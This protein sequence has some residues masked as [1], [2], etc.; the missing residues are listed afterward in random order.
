MGLGLLV[1]FV[2]IP[3]IIAMAIV[4]DYQRQ[5]DVWHKL[6][7][8][9]LKLEFEYEHGLYILIQRVSQA[10]RTDAQS[11]EALADL[12]FLVDVHK[13]DCNNP[14]CSCDKL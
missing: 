4:L 13:R 8:G 1:G 3:S 2:S 11:N 9:T 5:R 7:R 12:M 14:H 10:M 6:E